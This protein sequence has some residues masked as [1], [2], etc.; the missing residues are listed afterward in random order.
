[1]K[2]ELKRLLVKF[3]KSF[4]TVQADYCGN[5]KYNWHALAF[6]FVRWLIVQGTRESKISEV[7]GRFV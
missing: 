5:I 6:H 3:S 2:C 4:T 7:G 1:M